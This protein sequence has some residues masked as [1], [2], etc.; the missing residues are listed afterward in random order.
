MHGDPVDLVYRHAQP[1]GSTSYCGVALGLHSRAA[2]LV[3]IDG[4]KIVAYE[5]LKSTYHEN[6]RDVRSNIENLEL[7]AGTAFYNLTF[8]ILRF[9]RFI[10]ST[11]YRS[12]L[13]WIDLDGRIARL[14]N[15]CTAALEI[16]GQPPGILRLLTQNG[17]IL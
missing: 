16:E 10:F 6:R 2:E 9:E 17:N 5:N 1:L 8:V 13:K 3:Y 15:Q 4:K 14:C 11:S 12:G 7:P